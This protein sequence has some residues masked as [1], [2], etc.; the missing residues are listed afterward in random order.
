MGWD[1]NS[2]KE[3]AVHATIVFGA[4]MFRMWNLNILRESVIYYPVLILR[5]MYEIF[6]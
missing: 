3:N 5:K 6:Q 2:G 1:L 4:S